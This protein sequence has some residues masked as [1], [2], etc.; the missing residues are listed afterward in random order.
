MDIKLFG[1]YSFSNIVVMDPSLKDYISLKPVIVP[2]SYGRHAGER[3]K[4]SK[5][6]IVERFIN[7]L[8]IPGHRGKKHLKTSKICTGKYETAAKIVREVFDIIEKKANKNPIEVLVRAVENAGP[9]EETTVIEVGGIRIPKQV[10][11]APQRRVD[12]ALR[13]IVQGA[14]QAANSKHI[15]IKE[16]L[17]EELIAASNDDSKSF[18]VSKKIETE[19]QAAASG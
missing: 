8:F 10:D 19:R 14:F 12:L 4:K 17:A 2:K 6:N 15:P 3:L 1:K 9:R 7:K 5:V 13:W 16:L 11:V 18:A